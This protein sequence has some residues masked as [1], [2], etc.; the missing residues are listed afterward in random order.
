MAAAISHLLD[1]KAIELVPPDQ[2]RLGFYSR[3]FL[4]PKSSG[5]WRAILDLKSLYR[6]IIY[7][8]FKMH[9][10]QTI[11]EFIWE[12]DFLSS[13]DLTEAYLHVPILPAHRKFLRFYY[14]GCHY[15]YRALLFGLSS[16]PRV[17]SKLMA[18]LIAHIRALLILILFYLDDILILSKSEPL[19]HQDIQT[20]LHELQAHG[21]LI[22]WPKSVLIPSTYIQHLGALIDTTSS[23]V[24]LSPDCQTSLTDLAL[25]CSRDHSVPLLTLSRLLGKMVSSFGIVPWSRLHSR[26]L[27]WFLLPFLRART[28]TYLV[29]VTLPTKVLD[30]LGWWSSSAVSKGSRFRERHHLVITTDASLSGWGAHLESHM[31]QGLWLDQERQHNINWLELRTIYLALLQFHHLI[32]GQ[33]VLML[34]DNIS[35]KV[36]INRQGGTR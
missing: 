28:S 16:A 15:Q 36:H 23:L 2:R 24:S 22:N 7:R 18:A 1:I 11:L 12:G 4:V 3:L 27:Q 33:H 32:N 5:S 13:V 31:A 34:T 9:S 35:A 6:Y 21:F 10:L 30:S 25:H 20:V 29:K 14:A 19:A 26:Q 17:F 8:Q